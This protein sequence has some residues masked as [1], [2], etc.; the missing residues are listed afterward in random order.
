MSIFDPQAF[1]DIT[2]TDANVKRPPINEGDYQATIGEVKAASGAREDG[3]TWLQMLVPLEI[4]VP[5]DQQGRLGTDKI[6]LTDRV[7]IDLTDQGLMDNSVG[8][9]RGQRQYRD[10][11]DT[12]KAGE[13]FSWRM[14]QGRV[15]KVKIKHDLYEGDIQERPFGIAKP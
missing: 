9:N 1:L 5:P 14:L 2:V 12:N 7:F 11:T 8:R 15:V 4:S 6:I 13:P 3:T 10:A